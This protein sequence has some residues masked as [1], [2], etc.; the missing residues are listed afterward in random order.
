MKFTP[1]LLGISLA[2]TSMGVSFANP[3]K[4][5]QIE[6]YPVN[7]RPVKTSKVKKCFFKRFYVPAQRKHG[8]FIPAQYVT[9]KVCQ[10][11]VVKH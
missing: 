7:S 2:V 6:A 1:V 11:V 9:K 8:V 3:A 5:G 4:A 10:F